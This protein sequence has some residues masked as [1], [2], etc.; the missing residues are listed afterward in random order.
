MLPPS[1]VQ[2]QAPGTLDTG[3][4]LHSATPP[5]M[6]KEPPMSTE[7]PCSPFTSTEEAIRLQ[8][9]VGPLA[10]SEA[11]SSHTRIQGSG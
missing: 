7:P 3:L 2:W 1:H 10:Q 6:S 4:Q 9:A 5:P 11:L 8:W